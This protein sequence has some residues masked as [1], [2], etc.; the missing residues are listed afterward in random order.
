[1]TD[2]EYANRIRETVK[3]LNKLIVEAKATGLNIELN[4]QGLGETTWNGYLKSA[5]VTRIY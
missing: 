1:M 5:R 4:F 2:Q 3:D